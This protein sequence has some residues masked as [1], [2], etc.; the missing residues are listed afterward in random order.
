MTT[1]HWRYL[2]TSTAI[3][4]LLVPFP[5]LSI[6]QTNNA[7]PKVLTLEDA[8]NYALQH[9]PAIRVALEQQAAAQAAIG[10]AKTSY[11]PSANL[12]WQS[13]RATDNNITGLLLPN[14]VVPSISG[15]VLPSTSNRSVWGSA[16]GLLFSWTAYDFGYRHASVDAARAGETLAA[17]QSTVTR[18]DVAVA[19]TNAFLTLLA[20]EQTLGIA[21]AD[22][23]RRDVFAK[24]THVLVQTQLRPGADAS[25]SDAE[26]AAARISLARDEQQVEVSRAALAAMLGM[27]GTFI[28]INPRPLLDPPPEENPP[29]TPL[30]SNPTAVAQQARVAEQK[31][32]I[33]AIERSD[34]PTF[35][36]QSAI[37]GRG[38]GANFNGTFETG[39][40]GLGLNRENW[41]AGI[42][43]FFPLSEI[44]TAHAQ[45]NIAMAQEQAEEARYQ[46]TIQDLTGQLAQ[47]QAALN[48]S[49]G[50]AAETPVEL[51]SAKVAET[52]AV[53]RYKAGLGTVVEVAEAQSL[54]VQAQADDALA[55]LAVW[56][57]LASVAAAQG[58]LG[59]F[60]QYVQQK[61]PGGN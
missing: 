42:L 35:N 34:Y 26:L 38:S 10:L 22:V 29:T 12:L 59:P 13:N 5:N 52:Q 19:T 58:N 36:F 4:L 31:S 20:A 27:A 25:R 3:L 8:V 61:T 24:S 6:A 54:L 47:A 44:F 30:R 11:L 43:V 33:R 45:K 51:S 46:Q 41:A 1:N 49:R 57:N 55:R 50:V 32:L 9:Y 53:A 17:A 16:A 18:L 2:R 48:G 21:Q 14:G 23:Q 40:N 39:A 7:P 15:P 37:Y 56:Q 60:L 28:E